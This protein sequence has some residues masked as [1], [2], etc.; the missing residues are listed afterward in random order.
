MAMQL[1]PFGSSG[2]E[3]TP[4]TLGSW[5]MSGDRYGRIDDS[6]AVR[7]IRQAL[8]LGITCF[9]TAPG[10]GSGHAEETL[11]AALSDRRD[12]AVVVTKCGIVPRAH[13]S[14]QPGR[15]SSRESIMREIDDSLS[16]LRTDHVDVYLVHWP[17]PET[18][19]QET[20]ATLDEIQQAGKTRLVGVSNF[21]VPL[22]E[23][24]QRLRRIDVLQVGYNL[25]D[26]RMERDI[27]PFCKAN[28]IGVMAY[29]SLAY[30]LLTGAF[31]D[32]TTFEPS[33]WR[34]GG[35]AFGQPI[36][37]GDN[38]RT[39]VRLVQRLR[40]EIAAPKGVS[41]A[42]LALAWVIGN[43]VVTTAM[44]GARVPAEIE[45]NI[46]AATIELSS[47][48]RARIEELMSGAAGQ[49]QAF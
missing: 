1:R 3:V 48:E 11:G 10:Y 45:E 36:L 35:V 26:R 47:D 19:L 22:L 21:D 34:A 6:E 38:F 30:G 27:F 16:R 7:T 14:N 33:D 29:G 8:D 44:V 20:M 13:Y 31:D 12:E 18:P 23:Q 49:V 17:D 5:P 42:Q 32:S 41:V 43:P 4:I 39:N 9:D 40:D 28:G 24:C 15:D 37:G 2:L 25:F 46:G